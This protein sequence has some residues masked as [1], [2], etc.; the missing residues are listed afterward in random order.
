[1]KKELFLVYLAFF[2]SLLI[3]YLTLS[4][5]IKLERQPFGGVIKSIENCENGKIITL[6]SYHQRSYF[7]RPIEKIEKTFM[8]SEDPN[9]KPES[10]ENK[11]YGIKSKYLTPSKPIETG[12]IFIGTA[13]P[14]GSCLEKRTREVTKII[15][16]PDGT[17]TTTTSTEEYIA[18]RKDTDYTIIIM[19]RVL[20]CRLTHLKEICP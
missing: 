2:F 3:P 7:Q 6:E 1:M 12:V 11:S 8:L 13:K 10:G 4:F 19:G 5:H 14:E 9:L 20:P 16:L 15:T 17:S 18:V